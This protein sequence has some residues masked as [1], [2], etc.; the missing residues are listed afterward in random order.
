MLKLYQ[1]HYHFVL[2]TKTTLSD[3]SSSPASHTPI[4]N[5]TCLLQSH[6]W[7]W[8][9]TI[10]G[11]LGNASKRSCLWYVGRLDAMSKGK[12]LHCTNMDSVHAY[13]LC[14]FLTCAW[15]E[16][17]WPWEGRRKE[18]GKEYI[19]SQPLWPSLPFFFQS[20][21]KQSCLQP[22]PPNAAMFLYQPVFLPAFPT[23]SLCTLYSYTN[24]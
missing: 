9:E 6:L 1:G 7:T 22:L 3:R 8:T 2:L 16:M 11:R 15:V 4:S 24:T 23:H 21:S 17:T 19:H 18:I 5:T 14:T 10:T 13:T 20:L 12:C